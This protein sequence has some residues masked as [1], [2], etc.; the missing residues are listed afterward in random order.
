MWPQ[1]HYGTKDRH[2]GSHESYLMML[3]AIDQMREQVVGLHHMAASGGANQAVT[4]EIEQRIQYVHQ[5]LIIQRRHIVGLHDRIMDTAERWHK[6]LE[7]VES[8]ARKRVARRVSELSADAIDDGFDPRG[9]FV[10]VLSYRDEIMYV[11]QSRNILSRL[12]QHMTNRER[13]HKVDHIA[14]FR[15]KNERAMTELEDHLIADNRPP[16]NIRGIT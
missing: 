4:D 9:F 2:W 13:R 12:G 8:S 6:R 11:G 10:Y 7:K 14:L 15:C 1:R 16:W 5:S 3:E